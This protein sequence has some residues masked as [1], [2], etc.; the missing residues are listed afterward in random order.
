MDT[1]FL[2]QFI[3]KPTRGN[4]I[5]DLALSNNE[6]LIQHY[7]STPTTF[8]DHNFLDI[9]LNYN[10]QRIP[11]DNSNERKS[12]LSKFNYSNAD[13]DQ[14]SHALKEIN[15]TTVLGD[16][17]A[18]KAHNFLTKVEE[19][20]KNILPI[21]E[22]KSTLKLIHRERQVLMRKR[23]RIMQRLK[24][25]ITQT[26]T[27]NLLNSLHEIEKKRYK[28]YLPHLVNRKKKKQ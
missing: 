25:S 20:C 10:Q 27:K 23:T 11:T 28:M 8:S 7:L 12:P 14:L 13:W 19:V 26:N 22:H 15:W 16:N 9:T 6:L 5:L 1:L 17:S 4:N 3:L 21:K 2:N 24:A 18:N